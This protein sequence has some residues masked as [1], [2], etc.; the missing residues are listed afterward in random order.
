M[1]CIFKLLRRAKERNVENENKP[2]R[3]NRT[4]HTLQGPSSCLA[5]D[6]NYQLIYSLSIKISSEANS[7][8]FR[9]LKINMAPIRNSSSRSSNR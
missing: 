1:K 4:E 5:H 2:E 6:S 8:Q 9:W 7:I 3:T